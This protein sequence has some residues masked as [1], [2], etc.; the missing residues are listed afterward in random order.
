MQTE[1]TEHFYKETS[2]KYGIKASQ[3]DRLVGNPEKKQD[4][5]LEGDLQL[6]FFVGPIPMSRPKQYLL[7]YGH[8]NGYTL[9][10]SRA[11]R[12]YFDYKEKVA[13]LT[14]VQ[15]LNEFA[16]RFGLEVTVGRL[17]GKFL[18][19]QKIPIDHGVSPTQLVSV[20]N[21]NNHAFTQE[22]WMRINEKEEER[23][24]DCALVFCI[25]NTRYIKYLH[26]K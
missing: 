4:V 20:H 11:Y 8:V 22:M 13:E 14:P 9:R 17:K 16:N 21:P 5:E 7:T 23:V 1:Y 12:L 15:L 2:K 26:R 24:V 10:I 6:Q 25:D 19:D 3:V 18:F